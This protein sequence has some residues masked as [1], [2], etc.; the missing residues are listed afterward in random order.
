MVTGFEIFGAV[1]TCVA[2]LNLARQGYESLAKNSRDYGKAGPDILAARRHCLQ[3]YFIVQ[4]WTTLWGFDIPMKD[5][6]YKAYWGEHGWKLIETQLAIVSKK[7]ADLAA[8][9]SKALPQS[10]TYQRLP[11]DEENRVRACLDQRRSLRKGKYSKVPMLSKKEKVEEIRRLEEQITESTNKLKK[12]KYVVSSSKKVQEH[13]QA[14]QDDFDRLTQLVE[15]AWQSQ[16][17]GVDFKTST[18]EERH[19]IALTQSNLF[20]I[21]K[22]K[23]DSVATREL[24]SWCSATQKAVKIEMSLLDFTGDSQSKRFHLFVPQSQ[25]DG[26]LEV[27]TAILRDDIVLDKLQFQ[28]NFLGACDAVHREDECLLLSSKSIQNGSVEFPREIRRR[29][30]FRLK[31][32]AIHARTLNLPSL[33]DRIDGLVVAERLEL[34][35]GI[36]ETGLLLLGTPWLSDLSNV[37]LKRFEANKKAPR[38]I[39]DIDQRHNLVRTQLGDQG[40][41]LYQYIFT[42]GITLAEIALRCMIRD[43]RRSISGFELFVAWLDGLKWRSL[44]HVVSL[45]KIELGNDYSKAVEFCLQ[46]PVHAPNRL[47]KRGVLYDVTRSEEQ[48]NLELLDLFYEKVL[49]RLEP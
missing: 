11:E 42:I 46:D 49:I 41:D 39:L 1:G 29:S 28:T 32:R 6:L 26:H 2:L 19:T 24:Y 9:M 35:Y 15:T 18:R 31:K 48:I 10:E 27:S 23:E 3:I 7:C 30:C 36:V 45:V 21:Q 17:P 38:Y 25:D 43:I 33:S 22:A 16:H 37:A 34:A 13:L 47:W 14:L 20:L 44:D 5:E 8:V 4:T 12:V 40:R